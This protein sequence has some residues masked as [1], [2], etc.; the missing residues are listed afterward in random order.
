MSHPDDPHD[1]ARL[2]RREF[3]LLSAS[4]AAAGLLPGASAAAQA[5]VP[6][7]GAAPL[8][9]VGFDSRSWLV[10]GKPVYVHS[11]EFHYFRVPEGRLA[12]AHAAV[13]GRRRQLPGH[14]RAVAAARA[15]GGPSSSS[16]ARRLAGLRGFCETAA[17]GRACTSMAR[18]GPY[19][20]SELRYDGL[21]GWLYEELPPAPGPRRSTASRIRSV[22]DLLHAPAVAGEGAAL[23]RPRLPA[24][25][26][27]TPSPPRRPGAVRAVRQRADGHPRLVRRARTTTPRRWASAGPTGDTRGSSQARH[28]DARD[29][30]P[31]L[32][33]QLR[34]RSPR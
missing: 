11:G 23:V 3:A 20:Y 17:R 34:Q 28:G 10:G 26:T 7:A 21:P 16:A 30:Q 9:A 2:T 1:T 13:Q 29:A 19:Q 5:P 31:P 8:P 18:P 27:G 22:V 14:L 32:R 12:G 25:S 24:A 6:A 15:R 33:N 4:A